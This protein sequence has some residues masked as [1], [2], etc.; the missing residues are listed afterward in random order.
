MKPRIFIASSVESKLIAEALQANLEYD[1]HCT[2]WDQAFTLSVST[3]DKLLQYCA[4][5]D[6]AIF[7]FS[8]DDAALIRGTTYSVARDNVLF[9]CGLFMGMHGK[10]SAFI[11]IPRDSPPLHIPT[12]LL[13][14]TTANYDGDRAKAEARPALGTAT[15]EIKRAIERSAW[16][17]LK[18]TV[19]RKGSASGK[20]Y[21]SR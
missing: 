17:R 6:F 10:D 16:T 2:I 4:D 12:D 21:P 13:G 14:F 7:V 3:I 15:S 11:V 19:V 8:K 1:A 9:E 18:P 5:H 20:T